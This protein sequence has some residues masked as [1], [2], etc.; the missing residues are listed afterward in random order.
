[1]TWIFVSN[2]DGFLLAS[3]GD[4]SPGFNEALNDSIGSR[5]PRSHPEG[6]STYWIDRADNELRQAEDGD[7]LLFGN[8]TSLI[9]SG[10]HVVAHSLYEMFDD[11]EMPIDEFRS[12]LDAWRSAIHAAATA[13]S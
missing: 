11:E 1:V 8:G 2:E 10:D 7:V 13:G 12:G 9:K 3:L 5:A 6:L 4:T